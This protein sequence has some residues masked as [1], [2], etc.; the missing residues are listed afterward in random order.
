METVTHR[1]RDGW[2]GRMNEVKNGKIKRQGHMDRN[3]L[4]YR[5][6]KTTR[7]QVLKNDRAPQREGLTERVET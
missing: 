2:V 6:S 4:G 5:N 3:Q 7:G 1:P